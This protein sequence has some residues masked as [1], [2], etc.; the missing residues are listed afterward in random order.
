MGEEIEAF[1][2]LN[3]LLECVLGSA[4]EGHNVVGL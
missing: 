4:S 1:F 3:L 2:F